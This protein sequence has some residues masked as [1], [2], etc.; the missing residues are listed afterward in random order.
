M[1]KTNISR[2]TYRPWLGAITPQLQFFVYLLLE[3]VHQQ[4]GANNMERDLFTCKDGGTMGVDWYV[5]ADGKGR[6]DVNANT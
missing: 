5:D 2:L 3:T 6:P 4:L 1:T